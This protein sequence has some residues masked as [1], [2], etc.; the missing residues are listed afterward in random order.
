MPY[1]K[2]LGPVAVEAE[3]NYT[4]GDAINGEYSY[5]KPEN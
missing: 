4:W 2:P 3:V 1:A 5:D